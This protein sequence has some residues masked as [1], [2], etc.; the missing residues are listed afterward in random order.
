M[1]LSELKYKLSNG[2][3]HNWLVAGPRGIPVT[4]IKPDPEGNLKLNI[5]R[6]FYDPDAGISEIPC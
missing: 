6:N 5:I 3:I 4:K 2:F 1:S